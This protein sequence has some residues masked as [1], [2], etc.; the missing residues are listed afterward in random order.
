MSAV[1][2]TTLVSVL[3]AVT[4]M[5]E[6]STALSGGVVERAAIGDGPLGRG[7]GAAPGADRFSG[8]ADGGAA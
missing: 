8:G 5:L 6:P 4:E 2:A 3:S 1:P 7:G